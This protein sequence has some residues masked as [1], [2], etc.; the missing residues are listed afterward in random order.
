MITHN[1]QITYTKN[2][3]NKK[4]QPSNINLT[5]F[6]FVNINKSLNFFILCAVE[7]TYFSYTSADSGTVVEVP[8]EK[9]MRT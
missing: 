3:I 9:Q 7:I 5:L 2:S 4:L 1:T 8:S 6:F